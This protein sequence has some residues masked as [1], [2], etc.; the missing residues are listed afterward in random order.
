M[1]GHSDWTADL[2]ADVGTHLGVD[3]ASDTCR[4]KGLH[5]SGALT[6]ELAEDQALQW[7]C[8]RDHAGLRHWEKFVF[9]LGL[10][11]TTATMR[12]PIGPIR[13]NPQS[14]A[15][16]LDVMREVVAVGRA[17]GVPLA[18]D[19]AEQRLEFADDVSADMTSSMYHDLERGTDWRCDGCRAVSSNSSGVSNTGS[20]EPSPKP[21]TI[22]S[23]A[24]GISSVLAQITVGREEQRG[25]IERPAVT[26]HDADHQ[27]QRVLRSDRGEPVD[28]RTGNID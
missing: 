8:P 14:R 28:R 22:R 17:H 11:A 5:T 18:E 13:E 26:L 2:T 25:A 24:V 4:V 1:P 10:S 19:Y 16:L 27:V 12:V 21:Q 3:P 15:L 9:L 20:V 7:T 6:V 23:A